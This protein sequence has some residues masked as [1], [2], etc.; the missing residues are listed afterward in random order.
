MLTLP[1]LL[2]LVDAY[3]SAA[4]D[5]ARNPDHVTAHAG[6][7]LARSSV[8]EALQ[9]LAP[10]GPRILDGPLDQARCETRRLYGRLT[11]YRLGRTCGALGLRVPNPYEADTAARAFAT[12]LLDGA[13]PR[14]TL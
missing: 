5:E 7:V 6:R 8:V 12:G 13:A 10:F 1:D 4:A 14:S 3:A 11:P 9:T 2:Q